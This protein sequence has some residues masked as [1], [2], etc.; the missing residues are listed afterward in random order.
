MNRL[1]RLL[2]ISLIAA[3]SACGGDQ[4]AVPNA[5]TGAPAEVAAPAPEAPAQSATEQDPGLAQTEAPVLEVVEESA[6]D[7]DDGDQQ[8][9]DEAVLAAIRENLEQS[10]PAAEPVA[11]RFEPGKHYTV[12]T[13][14][15]GTSSSP[16]SIEVAEVFW[17]GCPHC[18]TFDPHLDK[19]QADLPADVNFV[20]LPVMWNPT[21]QFHA[22]VFYTAEALG[23]L[24][25]MHEAIFREIHLNQKMLSTEEEIVEFFARFGVAESDFRNTFRS[26]AVDS[27]LN[28]AKSLT[29]RYKIRSVP[30]LIVNGKFVTNGPDVKSF[31]DMI[32]VAD[33]LVDR[34]RRRL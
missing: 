14:A 27:K 28:R 1:R 19:W 26:F 3:V 31:D 32:A 29:Q 15:Q 23:K 5:G 17:Y 12:L 25:E 22:R 6:G 13:T 2:T 21:N 20:R 16:E 24:D 9:E 10:A 18:F 33:E 7:A 30:L 4:D 11:W 8:S 34:E